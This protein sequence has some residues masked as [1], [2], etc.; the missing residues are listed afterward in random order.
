MK[1]KRRSTFG[2]RQNFELNFVNSMAKG[3]TN[4]THE[5]GSLFSIFVINCSPASWFYFM[6]IN[7]VITRMIRTRIV[8]IAFVIRFYFCIDNLVARNVTDF[9]N[10]G[11]FILPALILTD[12]CTTNTRLYTS[13]LLTFSHTVS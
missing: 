10:I 4:T 9:S 13:I 11:I 8:G 3:K 2:D 1:P 7:R 12:G 5:N 6:E